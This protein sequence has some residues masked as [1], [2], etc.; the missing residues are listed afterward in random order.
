MCGSRRIQGFWFFSFFFFSSYFFFFFYQHKSIAKCSNLFAFSFLSFCYFIPPTTKK[1]AYSMRHSILGEDINICL[2]LPFFSPLFS[3][4]PV[5]F[6]F[7]LFFQKKKIHIFFS[8]LPPSLSLSLSLSSYLTKGINNT[9][10]NTPP[11]FSLQTLFFLI[12][13]TGSVLI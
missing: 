2:T 10:Q 11:F 4:H 8:I 12:T 5:I 6:F 9:T 1:N 3:G 7:F 13:F